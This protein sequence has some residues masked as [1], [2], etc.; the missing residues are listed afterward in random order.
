MK[1]WR[2]ATAGCATVAIILGWLSVEKGLA[3]LY[4]NMRSGLEL[5]SGDVLGRPVELGDLSLSWQGIQIGPSRVLASAHDQSQLNVGGLTV[6]LNPLASLWQR[7][8]VVHLH[9]LDLR[10]DLRRNAQGSFWT[11][12]QEESQN[13]MP[14]ELWLHTQGPAQF[15]IWIEPE[16]EQQ[17]HLVL[18]AQGRVALGHA[19]HGTVAEGEALFHNSGRLSFKSQG[20]PLSQPWKIHG[21]ADDLQLAVLRPLLVDSPLRNL[22]GQVDGDMTLHWTEDRSCRGDVKLTAKALSGLD[23]AE[24]LGIQELGIDI[25]TLH[26]DGD[27]IQLASGSVRVGKLT[28]QVQGLLALD[29]DGDVNL[30]ASLMGPLPPALNPVVVGGE[31]DSEL[32]FFGSLTALESRINLNIDGWQ[33]RQS[34]VE[35]ITPEQQLLPPLEAQVQLASQWWPSVQDFQLGGSLQAQAGDSNLAVT[36]QWSPNAN[37]LQLESTTLNVAPREWLSPALADALF[38]PQPYE[39]HVAVDQTAA[40]QALRLRLHNPQLEEPLSLQ[41]ACDN[42]LELKACETSQLTGSFELAAGQLKGEATDGHWQLEADLTK[43]DLAP[44]LDRFPKIRDMLAKLSSPSPELTLAARLHGEYDLDDREFPLAG[45]RL[46]ASLPHGLRVSEDVLLDPDNQLQLV[47]EDGQ[48]KLDVR[49][50]IWHSDGVVHWS[51]GPSWQFW[52]KAGFDLNLNIDAFPLGAVGLLTADSQLDFSGQLSGALVGGDLESLLESLRL[53]GKLQLES[54]GLATPLPQ[55]SIHLP[56]TWSGRIQPLSD[57]RHD[58]DLKA[59]AG[60]HTSLIKRGPTLQAKFKLTSLPFDDFSLRAGEGRL[61]VV[62]AE[63]GY[64]F[65]AEDLPL[66]WLEVWQQDKSFQAPLLG[67]LKGE[68]TFSLSNQ[69]LEV[70]DA[71]V[72]IHSPRLGPFQDHQL[73]PPKRKEPETTLATRFGRLQDHQLKMTLKKQKQDHLGDLTVSYFDADEAD[74]NS[75]KSPLTLTCQDDQQPGKNQQWSCQG[76]L[77]EFPLRL[78]RQ[79][80][81]LVTAISQGSQFGRADDLVVRSGSKPLGEIFADAQEHFKGI[82]DQLEKSNDLDWLLRPLQGHVNGRLHIKGAT[83]Q[84]VH[85]SLKDTSLNFWL[86]E[87]GKD[88]DLS[89][90]GK[91]MQLEFEGPLGGKSKSWFRFSGLPLRLVALLN[92]KASRA[93]SCISQSSC[94]DEGKEP[95]LLHV[96]RKFPLEGQLKGSGTAQNLFSSEQDIKVTLGL[97]EG[98]LNGRGISLGWDRDVLEDLQSKEGFMKAKAMLRKALE[99]SRLSDARRESIQQRL[100]TTEKR[101]RKF[102]ESMGLLE[103][104]LNLRWKG[105]TLATNLAFQSTSGKGQDFLELYGWIRPSDGE[106]KLKFVL[107]DEALPLILSSSDDDLTFLEDLSGGKVVAKKGKAFVQNITLTGNMKQLMISGDGTVEGF[108]G[109]VAGIPIDFSGRVKIES[110]TNK[111]IFYSYAKNNMDEPLEVAIG[112]L[113]TIANYTGSWYYK[114]TEPTEGS[115]PYGACSEDAVTGTSVN[116]TGLTAGTSYTFKLYSDSSCKTEIASHSFSTTGKIKVSGKLDLWEPP[117]KPK[118]EQGVTVKIENVRLENLDVGPLKA[119]FLANGELALKGS[120]FPL[121]IEIGKRLQL[122]EGR[123]YDSFD[124]KSREP[125]HSIFDQSAERSQSSAI[126]E[127]EWLSLKELQVDFDDF[128]LALEAFRGHFTFANEEPFQISGSIGPTLKVNSLVF[129]NAG[130]S[131]LTDSVKSELKVDGKIKLLKGE[132]D[133]LGLLLGLDQ[134]AENVVIFSSKENDDVNKGIYLDVA[135]WS[136]VIAIAKD[137]YLANGEIDHTLKNK[138]SFGKGRVVATVKGDLQQDQLKYLSK[139]EFFFSDIFEI[140]HN[141]GL[142]EDRLA[143]LFAFDISGKVLGDSIFM[144]FRKPSSSTHLDHNSPT[145]ILKNALGTLDQKTTFALLPTSLLPGGD[146]DGIKAASEDTLSMELLFNISSRLSLS[147][148]SHLDS[149]GDLDTSYGLDFHLSPIITATFGADR[150]RNWEAALGFGYRF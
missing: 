21:E 118:E 117:K 70:P 111:V 42:L 27:H 22:S 43:Q 52:Q 148:V 113:L 25:P 132:I 15:K 99:S 81:E 7:R 114:R 141:L 19:R 91:P 130:D 45:G 88:H 33:R 115:H 144:A 66:A 92:P 98:Q 150:D 129:A 143:N 51:P 138:D 10:G 57:G 28:G 26:C 79:G 5:R 126:P 60:N 107:T 105:A 86:S 34:T 106:L 120:V 136:P 90:H 58:L 62:A 142:S 83:G 103:K 29:G 121:K 78:L 23:W 131:Q 102:L 101:E 122:S 61:E 69:Q 140:E 82:A 72:N 145:N 147:A 32:H 2:L 104:E 24:E 74:S 12:K 41:L 40:G 75:T 37:A 146:S 94:S 44:V 77:E 31:L 17:P 53:N 134:N 38:P 30:N 56:Q 13:P 48:W 80:V 35:T 87:D 116:L 49:S 76:D 54:I 71:T 39:G 93:W 18:T 109:S 64:R 63:D 84:P 47:G 59:Q 6:S 9:V 97:Q 4:S 127:I 85:A 14:A 135:M 11:I 96:L 67:K 100:E 149:G 119:G 36:G 65:T 128:D 123:L 46:T 3:A 50:P 73:E 1:P 20:T 16:S 89:A 124:S 112:S 108:Q 110:G 139:L 125:E 95:D 55:T 68:G 133:Y 8:W 137:T